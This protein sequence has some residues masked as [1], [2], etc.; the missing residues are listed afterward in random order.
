MPSPGMQI[1]AGRWEVKLRP[2]VLTQDHTK[3]LMSEKA[4]ICIKENYKFKEKKKKKPLQKLVHKWQQKAE[5]ATEFQ[6]RSK[7]NIYR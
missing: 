4:A 3:S 1:I 5:E 7:I 2:V 6:Y